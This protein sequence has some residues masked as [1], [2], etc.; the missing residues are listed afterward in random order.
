MRGL[1]HEIGRTTVATILADHGIEPAP[2]RR[3]KMSWKTFLKAHWEVLA[4]MDFFTVEVVT[5][6]GLVR[7][8]VLFVM[9]LSTRKVHIAGITCQPGEAWMRN[10]AR[11][12]TG[13]F[14]G[15]LLGKR[16]LI[17]VVG[18]MNGLFARVDG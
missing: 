14:D 7:Y 9:E 2:E 3:K 11:H 10:M 8:S 13:G 1:G 5:L 6:G 15:F 16:Y 17:L 18:N 12:L 4:A